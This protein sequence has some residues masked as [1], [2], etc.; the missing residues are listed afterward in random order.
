MVRPKYFIDHHL[1]RKRSRRILES[2]R[3]NNFIKS[4]K[5]LL[6]NAKILFWSKMFHVKQLQQPYSSNR[7]LL[8]TKMFHVK[9]FAKS[10]ENAVI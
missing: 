6:K 10:K 4:H 7:L 5:N 1:E 8:Q 2:K 9:H 3:R